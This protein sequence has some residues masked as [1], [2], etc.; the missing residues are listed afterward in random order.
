MP[1][2]TFVKKARKAIP[3][4]GIK[5]GDAYYWWKFRFG[6]IHRSLTPPKPSQLTQSTFLSTVL[7][8]Q[9]QA[10]DITSR[11]RNGDLTCSDAESDLSNL[12]DE[13]RSAGEDAQSSLDNMPE[14]LQQG[15]TGQ[16][17]QERAD[18]AE[19]TADE[20]ENIDV[21]DDD[22]IDD[23][24]C[25][26]PADATDEQKEDAREA[27]RQELRETMADDIDGIDW[28]FS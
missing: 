4:A 28:S 20:L 7:G 15:D 16:L 6:G 22:T 27:K 1:N 21:P 10:E 5:A 14:G 18:Q 2:V 13:L 17:L 26:F 3:D 11:L 9:E 8:L 25:D 23:D 24:D 12:A 19:T